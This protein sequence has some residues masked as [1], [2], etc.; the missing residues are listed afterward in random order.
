MGS[1]YLKMK[2][3]NAMSTKNEIFTYCPSIEEKYA[4]DGAI[5]TLDLHQVPQNI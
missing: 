5:L 1:L 2:K 3:L 4:R